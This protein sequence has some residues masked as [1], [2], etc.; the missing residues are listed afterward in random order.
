V[1]RAVSTRLGTRR[2]HLGAQYSAVEVYDCNI[3]ADE[4]NLSGG[5]CNCTSLKGSAKNLIVPLIKLFAAYMKH[6]VQ[7]VKVAS[8]R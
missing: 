2:L 5:Q 6:P 4:A 1:Q 8:S 7:F 3:G